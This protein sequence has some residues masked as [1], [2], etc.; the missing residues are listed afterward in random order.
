MPFLSR[1]QFEKDLNKARKEGDSFSFTT[2]FIDKNGNKNTI[3]QTSKNFKKDTPRFSFSKEKPHLKNLPKL[4][5]KM[6][7]PKHLGKKRHKSKNPLKHAH[8]NSIKKNTGKGIGKIGHFAQSNINK[9]TAP[10][11]NL[12]KSPMTLM[13]ILG[14]GA[15]IVLKVT[16]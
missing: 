16:K 14:L 5:N 8:L 11:T 6:K 2:T 7:E 9:I 12:T 13:I 3:S 10:L 4:Y 1:K 15:F